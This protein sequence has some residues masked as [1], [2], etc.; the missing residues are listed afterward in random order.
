MSPCDDNYSSSARATLCISPFYGCDLTSAA[1]A[2]ACVRSK[3]SAR[4]FFSRYVFV[5]LHVAE[6]CALLQERMFG[7]RLASGAP[8]YR[9]LHD[10][11]RGSDAR[12][13]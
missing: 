3:R 5:L 4:I 11:S 9:S 7:V 2:R 10:G 12:K 1:A 6:E 13:P 8:P